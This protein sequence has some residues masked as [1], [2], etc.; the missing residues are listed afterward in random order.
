MISN[1]M[2]VT[3]LDSAR[4]FEHMEK[5]RSFVL[6]SDLLLRSQPSFKLFIMQLFPT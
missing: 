3:R 2:H 4:I 1:I 6:L 5:K